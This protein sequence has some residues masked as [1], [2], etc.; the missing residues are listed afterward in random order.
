MSPKLPV[1]TSRKLLRAFK[2][3]G[4]V[5]DHQVGSHISLI[6]PDKPHLTVTVPYHNRDMKKGTLKQILRQAD[7]DVKTLINLL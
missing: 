6:H 7:M 1:V 2:R 3:A 5:I 4:F